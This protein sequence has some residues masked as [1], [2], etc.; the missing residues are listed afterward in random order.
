[1]NLE[2]RYQFL[3]AVNPE[4]PKP[5][6]VGYREA[7]DPTLI[8]FKNTYFLF[9][10]MT[11]GFWTSED[12]Y[13]WEFHSFKGDIPIYAYAPD[14]RII[15]EYMYFCAS[16]M[17]EPCSFFRT[18][19]PR[20]EAFEEIKGTFAFWDPNLFADDD[21]RV[22]LYWGSSNQTPIYGVE[23]NPETMEP[24]GDKA[25]LIFAD[26]RHRGYERYGNEHVPP[27]TEEQIE[28]QVNAMYAGMLEQARATGR[29]DDVGMSEEAAKEMLRAYMGNSPFMEGAYMTKYN[30]RYYLQ[31]A[32]NGTEYNVYGDGVYVS[33]KPLGPFTPAENNP[34][35]YKP[36]G[37]IPGAGHGSTLEDKQGNFWHISTGVIANNHTM[38]RRLCLWK[39]GF[40]ED[41]ELYCDQRFG[42]WP[43]AM[44][45]GC[46]DKP[47]YMLLSFGCPVRVSSGEGAEN[48]TDE[49]IKTFWR[50]ST[51]EAG[52]WA[53]VD[54]GE[55]QSVNAVQVNFGDAG[56]FSDTFES[57]NISCSFYEE[58]YID[59]QIQKTRWLLEGSVDGETYEILC[60]RRK[61]DS[62]RSHE[63][64][65]FPEAKKLRCIR[66]TVEALPYGQPATVSG[67][68]VFGTGNGK[69]PGEATAVKTEF[70]SP[71]DLKVSWKAEGATG[72]VVLWGYAP[73]KLYHSRMVHGRE[74]A[75]IG[76]VV[77]GQS[78]YIRVDTFNKS[79]IAEGVVIP[80]KGN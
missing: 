28:A 24:V 74:E 76:G 73:D 30:G 29:G 65:E 37:F 26:D 75:M 72:A 63:F 64:V 19:D 45:A 3:R 50:A 10:S 38:E 18:R 69:A 49:N 14:V 40:D 32:F 9:P 52:E 43:V 23:L 20:T 11:A 60:D 39:A 71:L 15:G 5:P 22:Y 8:L 25:E 31:Y 47:D 27:K 56:L 34:Y 42:D 21:G 1:M 2:Y 13:S 35:S 59:L 17:N 55:V 51:S 66:L 68:R 16:G 46:F 41:G 62:D 53:V 48:V 54:L 12:L 57:D 36:G 78:L 77:A 58:R 79:K 6:F 67:I 61:A 80:V 44:D 70:I 7:A 33:D 4:Q